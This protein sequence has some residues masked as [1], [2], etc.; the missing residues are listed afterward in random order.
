MSV[1]APRQPVE[2][3]AFW[4]EE[5]NYG[6][7][8][9]ANPTS[10]NFRAG[11]L[12]VFVHGIFGHCGESWQSM[13]R[14]ALEA[15]KIDADVFSFSFPSSLTEDADIKQAAKDLQTALALRFPY[16]RYIYFCA[17]STGGLV[18]KA[19]LLMEAK[20]LLLK[21]DQRSQDFRFIFSLTLRTR[22]IFNF[23][24]PHGGGEFWKSWGGMLA[25]HLITRPVLKLLRVLR[26][27]KYPVGRNWIVDQLVCKNKWVVGLE[28]EYAESLKRLDARGV[29][30]PISIEV[31]ARDRMIAGFSPEEYGGRQVWTRA[32]NETISVRKKHSAH[33]LQPIV[34]KG[35]LSR[36]LSD[37]PR[38]LALA[39]ETLSL[40]YD[41]ERA[42]RLNNL[43]GDLVC[44][45]VSA[46]GAS[47][48]TQAYID[49][50]VR[51]F[52]GRGAQAPRRA[53]ITGDAGVGKSVVIR[54]L[55]RK[56]ALDWRDTDSGE[57]P[58]PI[59]IPLQR[60]K[61]PGKEEPERGSTRF[62]AE[63][64]NRGPQDG[65][66]WKVLAEDWCDYVNGMFQHERTPAERSQES[67][68]SLPQ[69]EWNW[70][71][72]LLRDSPAVL[73]FDAVD[74]FLSNN[75]L[76][77]FGAFQKM[78]EQVQDRYAT[79]N[80]LTILLGVRS[81][82]G[83]IDTLVERCENVFCVR[84]L[85]L[86]E[87][88]QIYPGARTWIENVCEHGRACGSN[89]E[90]LKDLLLTPLI[91]AQLGPRFSSLN[92]GKL[93]SRAAILEAALESIVK[94]RDSSMA[95]GELTQ[96]VDFASLKDAMS[97]V[98]WL[99]YVGL[100]PTLH[101]DVI[102]TRAASAI[103][104]W[105]KLLSPPKGLVDRYAILAEP[106]PMLNQLITR[107]RLAAERSTLEII[108]RTIFFPT[109]EGTYRFLHT[110]W[111]NFLASGY[112]ASI[113]CY[114]HADPLGERACKQNILSLAGEQL[115]KV[116]ITSERVELFL[117]RSADLGTPYVAGNYIALVNNSIIPMDDPAISMVFNAFNGV[118]PLDRTA[119]MAAGGAFA[120]V[121]LAGL[122]YRA[123]KAEL[124]SNGAELDPAASTIRKKLVELAEAI[125][126][127]KHPVSAVPI[128]VNMAWSYL[129]KLGHSQAAPLN[130]EELTRQLTTRSLDH[131][132]ATLL[133]VCTKTDAR[134]WISPVNR[135]L[136]RAFLEI[137]RTVTEG[138]DQG[139]LIS[140]IHYLFILV[141]AHHYGA[142]ISEVHA[143][144]PKLLASGSELEAKVLESAV[145]PLLA[146]YRTC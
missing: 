10:E 128:L 94:K 73:I 118:R 50:Q 2:R 93:V 134:F 144:L 57:K 37:D 5:D 30:R 132:E 105:E 106:L 52:I 1:F 110:E 124:R 120:T 38:S 137:Q 34:V 11:I 91:L 15:A 36:R 56:L 31:L 42:I 19:A 116:T 97:L 46:D 55:A 18:V 109:E 90:E 47:V 66:A 26:A 143:E 35:I 136:Q 24:V 139:R 98:G 104:E 17:H 121:T 84:R 8:H 51:A 122:G 48:G 113:V 3:P 99:F 123:L 33:K 16:H 131:D 69:V 58:L 85:R 100:E 20:H 117:G 141:L 59:V 108:M 23:D 125:V 40:I 95:N 28:K 49:E 87:A 7:V 119:G 78:L 43:I 102:R 138:G 12:L 111:Q 101:P 92:P 133:Q 88:D 89:G 61:L 22:R 71:D 103:R 9:R 126:A 140:T 63:D 29:Q 68:S 65:T 70:L 142:G 25:Y 115:T 79:N 127:S 107:M 45:E 83:G 13:P 81:S 76:I 27:W 130:T 62:F 41:Y 145:P 96:G 129:V 44:G 54:R 32:D 75:L 74:E 6:W 4:S 82:Q 77:G 39:S 86:D 21:I 14:E 114:N 53:V 67:A 112:L 72:N 135:S 64:F 60:V 80:S 146:L